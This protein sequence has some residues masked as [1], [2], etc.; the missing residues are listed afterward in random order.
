MGPCLPKALFLIHKSSVYYSKVLGG[1]QDIFGKHKT[2]LA[3]LFGPAT[4]P[5]MN[6]LPGVFLIVKSKTCSPED[7]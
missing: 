1:H 7:D 4:F 5:W 3:V 2:S 6:F